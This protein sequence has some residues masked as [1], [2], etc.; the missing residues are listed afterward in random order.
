MSNRV[1]S[2]H[3]VNVKQK[4]KLSAMKQ[5]KLTN[6]WI[7]Y[8][9]PKRYGNEGEKPVRS[10]VTEGLNLGPKLFTLNKKF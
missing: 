6:I 10:H 5:K 1:I 4:Q 2:P 3:S 9:A 8:F 7:T